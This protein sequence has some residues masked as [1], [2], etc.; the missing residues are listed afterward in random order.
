MKS[1]LRL[2]SPKRAIQDFAGEW[3]QPTPHRWQILG[4]SIAATFAIFMLFIP[5]DVRGPPARPE[6]NYISTFDENRSE[7]EI[8]ATNCANQQLKDELQAKLEQR[9]EL[10]KEMYKTLGR[11][12]FID[13]D[14]MEAEIEAENAAAQGEAEV[15]EG[16]SEIELAMSV[17]EYCARADG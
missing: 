9:A 14:A 6:V 3:K 17:E 8:I 2:I 15:A 1:F 12:T 5:D 4:V 13:V 11:A 7:A 16:P 10:R